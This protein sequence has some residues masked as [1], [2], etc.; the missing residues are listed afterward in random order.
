[1]LEINSIRNSIKNNLLNLIFLLFLFG[2]IIY[3]SYNMNNF[4][5]VYLSVFLLSIIIIFGLILFIF[6]YIEKIIYNKLLNKN[7][8][9]LL[10]LLKEK[11]LIDIIYDYVGLDD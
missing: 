9:R 10:Y 4:L 11:H 3:Y 8:E 5:Y 1:M 2:L 6:N 7:K